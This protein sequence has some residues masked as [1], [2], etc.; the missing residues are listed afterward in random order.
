[1]RTLVLILFTCLI[2]QVNAQKRINY[3]SDYLTID[4][5]GNGC[6]YA[7]VYKS[8]SNVRMDFYDCNKKKVM[9]ENF[10]KGFRPLKDERELFRHGEQLTYFP[11]GVVSKR[12]YVTKAVP[13]NGKGSSYDSTGRLICTGTLLDNERQQGG[14]MDNLSNGRIRIEN[15]E[16]GRLTTAVILNS[17]GDTTNVYKYHPLFPGK[18][19]NTYIYDHGKLTVKKL[20]TLSGPGLDSIVET[21]DTFTNKFRVTYHVDYTA[22]HERVFV[23]ADRMAKFKS[24]EEELSGFIQRNILYPSDARDMGIEGKVIVKF[25]VETDGSV[26]HVEALGQNH[27]SLEKEAIRV[28]QKTSGM[29]LPA[30]QNGRTVRLMM[31]IP[32]VFKLQ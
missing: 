6:H 31:Q 16:Q 18:L 14:F 27:P 11:N 22:A 13:R 5:S 10:E 17:G 29:W 12:I 15:Y 4:W 20:H 7:L 24:G 30:S 3:F 26:S 32:I 23:S 19:Q 8:D 2:L 1:M 25:V 9:T 28:I 21:R